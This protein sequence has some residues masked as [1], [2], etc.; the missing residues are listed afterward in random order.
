[1]REEYITYTDTELRALL[2]QGIAIHRE[3][4]DSLEVVYTGDTIFGALLR[5]ENDFLFQAYLFI[6]EVTYLDGDAK[7]AV[8]RGHVH[9]S[10][11]V[12]NRHIFR[13]VTKLM[14]VHISA[15]FET[16]VYYSYH[17]F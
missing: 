8:E 17:F 6:V 2:T 10:D 5:P 16:S 7:K 13:H 11:I 12:Q 9:G 4:V 1:M 14:L 15:R 3:A